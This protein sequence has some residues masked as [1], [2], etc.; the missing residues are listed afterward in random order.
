MPIFHRTVCDNKVII[1]HYPICA[2]AS[3][4][5]LDATIEIAFT[6]T[7]AVFSMAKFLRF[8]MEINYENKRDGFKK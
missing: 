7:L 4:I 3:Q 6:M 5:G 1:S 2:K 8:G